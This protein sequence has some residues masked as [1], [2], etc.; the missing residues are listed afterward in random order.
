ME[1]C[2]EKCVAARRAPC[3]AVRQ[4]CFPPA[5]CP[6]A[7]R[8]GTSPSHL[9]HHHLCLS[10]ARLRPCPCLLPSSG[11]RQRTAGSKLPVRDSV[12]HFRRLSIRMCPPCLRDTSECPIATA[13]ASTPPPILRRTQARRLTQTIPFRTTAPRGGK[14]SRLERGSDLCHPAVQR[15]ELKEEAR[16]RSPDPPTC[17]LVCRGGAFHDSRWIRHHT[18]TGLAP[19]CPFSP[20]QQRKSAALYVENPKI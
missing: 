3:P 8:R 19:S 17:R 18:L 5:S 15:A 1:K 11:L 13:G 2:A 14:R 20:P 9:A 12:A 4:K 10:R 7:Q 16:S 6:A